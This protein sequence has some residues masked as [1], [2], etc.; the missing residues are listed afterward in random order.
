MQPDVRRIKLLPLERHG[1][2]LT[3][4]RR[5]EQYSPGRS[6]LAG[7]RWSDPADHAYGTVLGDADIRDLVKFV[8][9]GQIDTD[10]IINTG[11]IF[12]GDVAA[13]KKLYDSGIGTNKACAKCHG[14]D[15]LIAPIDA[16]SGFD[17]YPG[18]FSN[19]NPQEFLHKV[20]FGSPGA[21]MPGALTGGGTLQNVLDVGA[22]AQRLPRTPVGVP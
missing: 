13:G 14:A 2:I 8:R 5:A 11:G 20:R 3:I 10:T 7:V 12:T 15:G 22:Y 18:E 1:P 9:V 4:V 17:E 19:D 21:T 16:A 6:C